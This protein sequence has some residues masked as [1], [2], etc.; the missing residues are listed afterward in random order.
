MGPGEGIHG[1][2]LIDLTTSLVES[3]DTGSI[4]YP[5]IQPRVSLIF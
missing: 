5:Q 4:T 1:Q 3:T 2:K